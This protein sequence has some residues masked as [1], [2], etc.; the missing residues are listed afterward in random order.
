MKGPVTVLVAATIF[1]SGIIVAL[2]IFRL[3]ANKGTTEETVSET[4]IVKAVAEVKASGYQAVFLTNNQV[5][6]GKLTNYGTAN[7]VLREVY[8][9]RSGQSLQQAAPT[10]ELNSE[11]KVDSAGK[12]A[13]V[14]DL[15]LIKLGNELH[16]PMDLLKLNATQI[17]FV[18]D[19]GSTSRVVKAIEEYRAK[20]LK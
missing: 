19:L 4:K 16:G 6:F 18:E 8:Y 9:L 17:L 15:T 7:P 14:S 13:L 20:N 2:L 3:T 11:V 1:L 5:Y 10:G 12:N